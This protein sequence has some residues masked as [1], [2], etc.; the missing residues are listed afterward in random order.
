VTTPN[1][2]GAEALR[3]LRDGNGRFASNLLSVD[4]LLSYTRRAELSE[5]QQPFAIILGCSDSRVPA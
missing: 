2:T 4:S 3:R 1:V 5:G